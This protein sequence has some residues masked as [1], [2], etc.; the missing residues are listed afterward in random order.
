M[1][2]SHSRIVAELQVKVRNHYNE[3]T[4]PSNRPIN[5]KYSQG[6]SNTT[7]SKSYKSTSQQLDLTKLNHI[8]EIDTKSRLAIVEPRVT[9][10]ELVQATLKQGLI[11]LVVPEF[12]GITVGGAIMGA[13]GESSSFRWG[14]FHDACTKLEI[15]CGDGTLLEVS[16][17]KNSDLF[18]AISGSYGSLGILV[19]ATIK[20]IPACDFVHIKYHVFK[21][22]INTI[23]CIRNLSSSKDSVDFLDGIL[24]NK[25]LGVVI[26]GSLIDK[27]NAL[28]RLLPHYSNNSIGADW[29]YLHVKEIVKTSYT[30]YEETIPL[31]DYLFRYDQGAFWVGAYL[32]HTPLLSQF[33]RY[34]LFGS[35]SESKRSFNSEEI[36]KLHTPPIPKKI[37]R[38]IFHKLLSSQNLWKWLHSAEKWVQNR[39]IIQDF[40]IPDTHAEEF[41]QHILE[42]PGTY[43]IWLCPIQGTLEPQIFAPHL[44]SINGSSHNFINFGIYGLPSYSAPISQIIRNLEQKTEELDGRKVLYSNSYYNESEFWRIYD[45]NAYSALRAKTHSKGIWHE[46]TEKVLSI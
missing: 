29:Y 11:P 37:W 15:I 32:F 34:V 40:C 46:I 12:K 13:A 8:L 27:S 14:T 30:L 39:F 6:Q 35:I 42:T 9:M 28:Y 36:K 21:N 4:G 20:L 10:D 22:P 23:E 5:L 33:I 43:P 24:F 3:Y 44:A 16:A 2:E 25:D 38:A 19:K 18:Y 17:E 45:H 1:M 41:M 26:E 7:R 31:Y